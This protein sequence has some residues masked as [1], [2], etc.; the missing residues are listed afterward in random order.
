MQTAIE[1]S[2]PTQ[3]A[4][5]LQTSMQDT[6]ARDA[7]V[8]A[9]LPIVRRISRKLA[10]DDADADEVAQ[11]TMCVLLAALTQ[12]EQ[13]SRLETWIYALVRSQVGRKYR[14]MRALP[15]SA[16]PTIPDPHDELAFEH[17]AS[18]HGD[19][20]EALGTLSPLELSIVLGHDVEGLSSAE[21]A[22]RVRLSVGAVKSRLHRVHERL[23]AHLDS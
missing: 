22:T 23:R 2:S 1:S 16:L 6:N 12:F 4:A 8:R 14:R 19:L 17:T 9:V 20:S 10:H 13:R 15:F 5:R 3:L 21:L 7:L 11:D 18:A